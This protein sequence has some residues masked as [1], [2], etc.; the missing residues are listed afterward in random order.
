ML[1]QTFLILSNIYRRRLLFALLEDDS[2]ASISVPEV[3]DT[4]AKRLEVLQTEL[5]HTHLPKMEESGVVHWDRETSTVSK[6]PSFEEIRP[7]LELLDEHAAEFP[8][9]MR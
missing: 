9:T 1:D 8:G 5:V 2:Q 4:G 7:L 6:G 3:I